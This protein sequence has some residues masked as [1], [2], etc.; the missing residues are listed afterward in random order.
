[1]GLN[2]Q[3][4]DLKTKGFDYPPARSC[5]TLLHR[6]DRF[7]R[8]LRLSRIKTSAGYNS[9]P[10]KW[11]LIGLHLGK[12]VSILHQREGQE[13]IHHFDV[14]H[15]VFTPV[16]SEVHY[17]HASEVDALYLELDPQFVLQTAVEIGL[18][19]GEIVLRDDFGRPDPIIEQIAH[20]FLRELHLPAL[21]GQLYL[22]TLMM[23]LSIHLLRFYTENNFAPPQMPLSAEMERLKTRL[24]PAL[25][26]IHSHLSDDLA[27]EDIARV[28]YLTPYYF[29]RLFKQV[30]GISPYQY[31]IQQ[32]IETAKDLLK[33]PRLSVAEV[34]LMVGFVDHSHLIRHYKRLTGRSPRA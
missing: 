30:Y 3:S 9:N 21:G 16:G 22:D 15:V 2:A 26:Y 19:A 20:A 32:R 25:E 28:V 27:L 10:V 13:K 23:Q 14:G 31:V 33:N 5:F 7:S 6:D 24:L 1:M 12:P 17:A 18:P 4:F 8:Y 29:S 34:A 11:H